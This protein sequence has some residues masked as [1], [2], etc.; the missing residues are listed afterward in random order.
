[1]APPPSQVAAAGPTLDLEVHS[2]TSR[3]AAV[4]TK[5]PPPAA[6]RHTLTIT[7]L[8][9]PR[10]GSAWLQSVTVGGGSFL[11]PPPSPGQASGP[12]GRRMLFMGDSCECGLGK[13]WG[14]MGQ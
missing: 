4:L 10:T 8:T 6:G 7:K 12:S 1:M 13:W 11:A 5:H 3:Q 2:G 14:W 9:Q